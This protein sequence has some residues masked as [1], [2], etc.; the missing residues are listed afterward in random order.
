MLFDPGSGAVATFRHDP[1]KPAS[2]VRDAVQALAADASGRLWV[3]TAG[4]VDM[5][6]RDGDAF[7]HFSA[8]TAE[9]PDPRGNV[10]KV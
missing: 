7:R 2:L 6:P 10:V 1:A 5:L 8:V 9:H 3:G 4:G